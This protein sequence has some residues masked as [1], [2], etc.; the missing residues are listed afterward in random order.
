MIKLEYGVRCNDCGS[1]FD[2]E[3][4]PKLVGEGIAPRCNPCLARYKRRILLKHGVE[5]DN[6][7]W[8]QLGT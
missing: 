1:T 7:D 6:I 2:Q 5:H 8:R 3:N 4:E